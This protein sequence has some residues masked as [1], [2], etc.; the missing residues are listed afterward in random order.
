[1]FFSHE[2][3]KPNLPPESTLNVAAA[4]NLQPS[5]ST[6]IHHSVGSVKAQ[7]HNVLLEKAQHD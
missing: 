6:V 2:P 1:V 3:P 7:W 5:N 4:A